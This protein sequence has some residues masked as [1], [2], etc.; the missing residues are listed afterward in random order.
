MLVVSDAKTMINYG[1][2]YTSM[3]EKAEDAFGAIVAFEA[4]FCFVVS[5]VHFYLFTPIVAVSRLG[6][7]EQVRR[8][9]DGCT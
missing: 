6:Q 2:A 8:L 7:S 4:I 5:V 9:A 3:V 1:N